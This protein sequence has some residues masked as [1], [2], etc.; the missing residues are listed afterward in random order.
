M[1][2]KFIKWIMAGERKRNYGIKVLTKYKLP[3]FNPSTGKELYVDVRLTHD[4]EYN[5]ITGEKI[6]SFPRVRIVT[7]D[8]ERSYYARGFYDRHGE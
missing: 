2:N 3:R 4:N 7:S 8:S 6:S 1:K 5:D